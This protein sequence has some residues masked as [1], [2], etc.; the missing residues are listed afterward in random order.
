[1]HCGQLPHGQLFDPYYNITEGNR[2][3]SISLMGGIL[4]DARFNIYLAG[5]P[6]TS[7]YNSEGKA[8]SS[9]SV[10]VVNGLEN[11]VQEFLS[12][13]KE[14]RSLA[15]FTIQFG[16]DQLKLVIDKRDLN[17]DDNDIHYGYPICNGYLSPTTSELN[18]LQPSLQG[19]AFFTENNSSVSYSLSDIDLLMLLQSGNRVALAPDVLSNLLSILELHT[20]NPLADAAIHF[21]KLTNSVPVTA[22]ATEHLR[23]I[24]NM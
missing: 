6:P 10:V 12:S 7:I 15:S 1:M 8:L 3:I 19:T 13:L 2:Q 9:D 21:L 16:E 23:E 5:Y 14:I 18:E 20:N 24:L 22:L 17:S 11:S 4:A